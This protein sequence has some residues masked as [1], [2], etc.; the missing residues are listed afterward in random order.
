MP[1]RYNRLSQSL[2]CKAFTSAVTPGVDAKEK[3]K[4]NSEEREKNKQ[5][6][7]HETKAEQKPELRIN[8]QPIN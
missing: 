7:Q 8:P 3:K 2:L 1:R 6:H 5:K 4:K